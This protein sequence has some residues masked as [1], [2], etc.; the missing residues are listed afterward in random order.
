MGCFPGPWAA[1]ILATRRRTSRSLCIP[2]PPSSSVS[3]PESPGDRLAA[4]GNLGYL[5]SLGILPIFIVTNIALPVFIRKRHPG[6]FSVI[7]HAVFPAL[8]S[9]TFLAAIWLNIHPWPGSPLNVMPW[10]IIVVVVGAAVWGSVL[11]HRGS[12]TLERLGQV[13]FIE[14]EAMPEVQ[15]M[16]LLAQ[17]GPAHTPSHRPTLNHPPDTEENPHG[18]T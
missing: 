12:Q 6:E 4:F 13:L 7:L 17:P 9:V 15:D 2:S 10:I 14:A 8:S 11:K 18:T 3:S 5:S 16:E 1:P